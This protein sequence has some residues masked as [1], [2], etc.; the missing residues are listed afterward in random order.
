MCF[1]GAV[2]EIKLGRLK[3]TDKNNWTTQKYLAG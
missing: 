3:Y 1:K 2:E